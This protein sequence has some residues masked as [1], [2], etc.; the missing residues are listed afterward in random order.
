M[1]VLFPCPF[2]HS[3]YTKVSD[4]HTE[5]YEDAGTSLTNP[6]VSFTLIKRLH[7]EWPNIIYSNEALENTQGQLTV[8]GQ[9]LTSGG[10]NLNTSFFSFFYYFFFPAVVTQPPSHLL[11]FLFYSSQVQLRGGQS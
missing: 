5:L 2:S 9:T 8:L 1:S 4:L 3:F 7:S 10:D 11:A 6:L